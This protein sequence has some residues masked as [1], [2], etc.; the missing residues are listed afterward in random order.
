MAAKGKMLKKVGHVVLTL[1]F[2]HEGSQWVGTCLELG[3]S[4]F[5]ETLSQVQEELHDL[6]ADHLDALEA[7]GERARFFKKHG[8]KIRW[9]AP[10]DQIA[11]T[12]PYPPEIVGPSITASPLFQPH[13]FQCPDANEANLVAAGV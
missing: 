1:Q 9:D 2:E 13:I 10:A 3:T 11:L 12:V 4:T 5:A 7:V 6:V 8:I